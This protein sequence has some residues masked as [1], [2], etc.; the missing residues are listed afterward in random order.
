M[1]RCCFTALNIPKKGEEERKV[2]ARLTFDLNV[3]KA[4]K[5]SSDKLQQVMG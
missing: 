5:S 1:Y 4:E 3:L 2:N